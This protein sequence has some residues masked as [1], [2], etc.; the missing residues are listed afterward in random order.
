[1]FL[2]PNPH[3][4]DLGISFSIGINPY[5]IASAK[6]TQVIIL[7]ML[8][9]QAKCRFLVAHLRQQSGLLAPTVAQSLSHG[10]TTAA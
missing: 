5:L 9:M 2:S 8:L 1:M 3:S 10:K 6:T 4:E 7:R